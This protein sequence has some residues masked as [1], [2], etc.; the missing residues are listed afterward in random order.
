MH[1]STVLSASTENEKGREKMTRGTW[2]TEREKHAALANKEMLQREFC[3]VDLEFKLLIK[4]D[5]NALVRKN[6]D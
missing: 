1:T 3:L 2:G 6:K 4:G 5:L